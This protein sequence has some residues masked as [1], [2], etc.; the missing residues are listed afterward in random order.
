MTASFLAL[1]FLAPP[2]FLPTTSSSSS[3]LVVEGGRENRVRTSLG[4]CNASV[5]WNGWVDAHLYLYQYYIDVCI[6]NG[7]YL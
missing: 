6:C 7:T 1:G 4:G 2:F 5:G 3:R